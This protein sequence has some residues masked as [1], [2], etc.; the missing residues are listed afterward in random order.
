MGL[1]L[2][3]QIEEALETEVSPGCR[4]IRQSI[5]VHCVSKQKP[6]HLTFNHNFGKFSKFIH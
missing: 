4:H 1:R 6:I 5:H 2:H 3:F